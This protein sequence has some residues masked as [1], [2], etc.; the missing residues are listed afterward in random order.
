MK[1]EAVNLLT[2][3]DDNS[4]NYKLFEHEAF[5]TVEESSKLKIDMDM[6]GAHTKN[7]FLRDKKRNFYLISCLDHQE[8]DLKEIK[9]SLVCQGNLSLEVL[10]I[11]MKN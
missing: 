2:L 10:N 7:L 3:L 5:Y 4:V 9:K 8:I 11:F 1:L 6:Q